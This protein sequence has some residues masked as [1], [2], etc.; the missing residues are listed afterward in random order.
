MDIPFSD[1]G[2]KGIVHCGIHSAVIHKAVINEKIL[3][4]AFFPDQIQT[5]DKAFQ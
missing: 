1:H 3:F 5:A 2:N 4:P